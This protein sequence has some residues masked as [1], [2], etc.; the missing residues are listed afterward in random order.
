M[1]TDIKKQFGV[2]VRQLREEKNLSQEAFAVLAGLHRTYVGAVER[3][4]RN[5]SLESISALSQALDI[6]LSKLMRGVG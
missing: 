4:E 3:G 6:T 2:R 5:L 1:G